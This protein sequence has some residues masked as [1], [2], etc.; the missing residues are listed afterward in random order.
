M[1]GLYYAKIGWSKG[2]CVKIKSCTKLLKVR[3]VFRQLSYWKQQQF[4]KKLALQ[5]HKYWKLKFKVKY[6]TL[7]NNLVIWNIIYNPP[8]P[9]KYWPKGPEELWDHWP[10]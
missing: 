1:G 9:S 10:C 5:Q 8:R 3:M 4:K 7:N 6:N 2:F